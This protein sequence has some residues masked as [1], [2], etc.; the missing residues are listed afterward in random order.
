[1][2]DTQDLAPRKSGLKLSFNAPVTL[3]FVALCAVATCA[4]L[5]LGAQGLFMTYR[6]SLTDPLMYLRL[7]THVLGHAS[8]DHF[9]SNM[10]YILL[11]GPLLEEKHGSGE[12]AAVIIV[13][14]VVTGAINNIVFPDQALCGASGVCFAFILLSSITGISEG[15]IPVTFV[16]VAILFLGQQMI[17]GVFTIDNVSQI[18]HII[19]GI[20][21]A[22]AGFGLAA[23]DKQ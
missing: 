12:I 21:G 18:S 19:G 2:S 8:W 15:E 23:T 16:L 20:V 22:V 11:L 13:T 7:L 1:M 6:S 9:A 10:I 14:A 17:E 4:S 5:Y 3:C